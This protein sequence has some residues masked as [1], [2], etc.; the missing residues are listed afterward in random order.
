MTAV[1]HYALSLVFC[2][3]IGFQLG[4]GS[5]A[6]DD[7]REGKGKAFDLI[8]LLGNFVAIGYVIYGFKFVD[9]RYFIG[10]IALLILAG[11]YR[12]GKG[13]ATA[14]EESTMRVVLLGV[15]AAVPLLYHYV[16]A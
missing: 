8:Y 10:V 3:L 2:W 5:Q 9:G 16:L 12:T 14:R 1:E 11:G 6:I 4:V 13:F 15:Y 7:Q